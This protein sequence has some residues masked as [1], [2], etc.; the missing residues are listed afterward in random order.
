[1]IKTEDAWMEMGK[2]DKITTRK[3]SPQEQTSANL[4]MQLKKINSSS[5]Q[6]QKYTHFILE[7]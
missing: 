7:Q 5:Q 1:V 3:I 4:V 2:P 6:V